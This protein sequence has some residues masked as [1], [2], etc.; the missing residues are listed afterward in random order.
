MNYIDRVELTIVA[1]KQKFVLSVLNYVQEHYRDGD[2]SELAESLHYNVYW[3][4]KEIKKRTGKSYIELLQEKRLNQ[5]A[6]LLK[7]TKMS[8]IDIGMAVGYE[9]MSYFHRIF[10]KKFGCT[11]RQ[12]RIRTFFK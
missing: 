8:I 1:E 7:H 10:L 9:N 2:L 3:L 4:S 12:Y 11:P 5:A 6:Y